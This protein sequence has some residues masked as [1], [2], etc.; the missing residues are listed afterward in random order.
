[1]TPTSVLLFPALLAL[2]ELAAPYD[3]SVAAPPT[4]GAGPRAQAAKSGQGVVVVSRFLGG[5]K[6]GNTDLESRGETDILVASYDFAGSVQWA[7]RFGGTGTDS[8]TS[9]ITLADGDF[10]VSGTF[11]GRIDFGRGRLRGPRNGRKQ[12]KVFLAR[13]SPAG[14]LKWSR[15]I[16]VAPLQFSPRLLLDSADGTIVV[17]G[18]SSG[19]VRFGREHR[20]GEGL[21]SASFSGAGKLLHLQLDVR[22]PEVVVCPD[23]CVPGRSPVRSANKDVYVKC[24]GVMSCANDVINGAFAFGQQRHPDCAVS[25]GEECVTAF[26]KGACGDACSCVHDF[27]ETGPPLTRCEG[28]AAVATRDPH[29]RDQ[30]WDG[31]CVGEVN[32][33]FPGRCACSHPVSR[34]GPPLPAGCNACATI[35]WSVDPYCNNQWW[36]ERCVN[37]VRARCS[38]E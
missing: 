38:G 24:T 2:A 28:S 1:M 15:Q 32:A 17:S 34:V 7:K 23:L 20:T 29:C 9:V 33:I 26:K 35:L 27:C 36:D 37:E 11:E 14:R 12:V 31:I 22:G 25:W 21:L 3:G 10:V 4:P 18:P 19:A 6:V 5:L 16:G 30:W 13:F 8:P